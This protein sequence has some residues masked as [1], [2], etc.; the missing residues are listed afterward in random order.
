[1]NARRPYGTRGRRLHLAGGARVS[2]VFAAALVG[3]V[4]GCGAPV[5]EQPIPLYGDDPVEYP[6]ELWDQALEG[7]TLL[8]IRITAEGVV[9]SVEVQESAGHPVLDSAAVAGVRELSF[10]PG[11]KGGKRVRMWATLPIE[12]SPRPRTSRSP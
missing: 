7:V 8:R 9:D 3:V 2:G 1:V 6:S 11:R 5:L 4:A 12:F 10:E